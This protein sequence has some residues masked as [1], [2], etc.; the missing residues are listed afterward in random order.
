M[1][2]QDF[3]STGN[4][5]LS[6]NESVGSDR[7]CRGGAGQETDSLRQWPPAGL[8]VQ[9]GLAALVLM[10][11]SLLASPPA[12][13]HALSESAFSEEI[14]LASF[15]QVWDQVRTQYFDFARIESDWASARTEL[16]P[17]AGQAESESELQ[18]VLEELLD[19]IGESHFNVLPAEFMNRL[20][21][22]PGGLADDDP[23]GM[24]AGPVSTG[25]SVRLVEGRIRVSD[26]GPG[27]AAWR[28]GIQPGWELL[29]VDGHALAGHL[30]EVNAAG[31][32]DEGR[33]ARLLLEMTLQ[34]RLAFPDGD[35]ELALDFLDHRGHEQQLNLAGTDEGVELVRL[36]HLPPLPFEFQL[37][38]I[39]LQEHC[40]MWLAFSTW[41]PELNQLMQQ[42]RDRAFQCHGLVI[43][44]RGNPGGVMTTMVTL[45]ADL[46]AQAA[47]LGSLLR[48]DGQID[49]R[50]L[51]RRVAMDGSRLQPFDGPV[52]ILLDSLSAST[53]EM[54][55]GGMQATGRARIFGETSAGMALPAQMLPLASGDYLMYAFADYRD[56]GGRRIEGIGVVP[57]EP[58]PLT[59][60]GLRQDQSPSLLAALDW[61][62]GQSQNHTSNTNLRKH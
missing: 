40:V 21:S 35:R 19:L 6:L 62:A 61:I 53:S 22:L 49:F 58:V 11:S 46:F 47:T 44:L 41:V 18:V 5:H 27:S 29:A 23:D 33:R 2:E 24:R 4:Q 34:G 57:D 42:Q 30:A 8:A 25:L 39:D 1:S 52:A 43:D 16:R 60:A 20:D 48:A 15:D 3:T 32:A 10:L 51:P 55:A 13:T 54:F 38:R 31:A 17:R 12:W 9:P 37:R 59:L 36:G 28:A 45:A 7:Q 14:A 50:V 56:S 26:V